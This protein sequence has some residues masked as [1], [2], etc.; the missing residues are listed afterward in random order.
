[1]KFIEKCKKQLFANMETGF[2]FNMSLGTPGRCRVCDRVV[3]SNGTV[4]TC[5]RC[6]GG[7]VLTNA[8][9]RLD[10]KQAPKK[11]TTTREKTKAREKRESDKKSAIVRRKQDNG[12]AFD[13]NGVLYKVDRPKYYNEKKRERPS[14]PKVSVQKALPPVVPLPPKFGHTSVIHWGCLASG[15]GCTDK[16]HTHYSEDDTFLGQY[17]RSLEPP[18]KTKSRKQFVVEL[19]EKTMQKAGATSIFAYHARPLADGQRL[20]DDNMWYIAPW[21]NDLVN[22]VRTYVRE[23]AN[24]VETLYQQVLAIEKKE[25][26]VRNRWNQWRFQHQLDST[27]Q[28]SRAMAQISVDAKQSLMSELNSFMHE[29]QIADHAHFASMDTLDEWAHRQINSFIDE[30]P[31]H[32]Q[33]SP[34]VRELTRAVFVRCIK[35][36]TIAHSEPKDILPLFEAFFGAYE[37]ALVDQ[38]QDFL[39]NN[40]TVLVNGGCDVAQIDPIDHEL[41]GR[42]VAHCIRL[43]VPA[44][45]LIPNG[46]TA[47]TMIAMVAA[48]NVCYECDNATNTFTQLWHQRVKWDEVMKTGILEW[49]R[50]YN[51]QPKPAPLEEDDALPGDPVPVPEPFATVADFVKLDHFQ[52]TIANTINVAEYGGLLREESAPTA[53]AARERVDFSL[54]DMLAEIAAHDSEQLRPSATV[55]TARASTICLFHPQHHLE[56]WWVFDSHGTPWVPAAQGHATL[57]WFPGRPELVRFLMRRFGGGDA[58]GPYSAF[59][60]RKVR[61]ALLPPTVV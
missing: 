56:P 9:K 33:R 15:K 4:V 20:S 7:E 44:Q 54:N 35:E 31:D 21:K 8:L 30:R 55:F 40:A 10:T 59:V 34:V 29:R 42:V 37:S 39:K 6:C 49:T 18:K 46:Q 60:M 27:L 36:C 16:T 45:S 11:S 48:V 3:N 24:L 28:S 41:K 1:M 38:L 23:K 32:E 22:L 43:P 53:A 51:A 26:R 61:S 58:P 52:H 17:E 19:P 2:N 12:L 50:W 5:N 14:K 57:T 47:C 13:K 25:E